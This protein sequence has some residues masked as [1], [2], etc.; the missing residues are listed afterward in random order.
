MF[1]SKSLTLKKINFQNI[2]VC[3]NN[4]QISVIFSFIFLQFSRN[5]S[6]KKLKHK[7]HTDVKE[8]C[9]IKVEKC[10]EIEIVMVRDTNIIKMHC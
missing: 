3:Q 6:L 8:K 2:S 4:I 10:M 1:S 7:M 5:S 9:P